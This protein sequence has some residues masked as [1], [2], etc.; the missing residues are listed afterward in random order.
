MGTLP[1][2]SLSTSRMHAPNPSLAAATTLLRSL[3]GLGLRH[4]VASPGSRNTPLLYAAADVGL[5]VWSVIDERSAGFAAL[6]AARTLGEPVAVTCTSGSAA[7]H[8]LPAVVE[9]SQ[10]RVPLLVLT[11]D[12]PDELRHTGAPQTVDQVGIYGSFVRWAVSTGT[13]EPTVAWMNH[14]AGTAARAW[15]ELSAGPVHVNLPFREPLGATLVGAGA[16]LATL[17]P[18]APPPVVA[19]VDAAPLV[20]RLGPRP[21]VVAGDGAGGPGLAA[22]ADR[23][24]VL[25]DPLTTGRR[26]PLLL[27]GNV[28]ARIGALDRHPPSGVLRIGGPPTSKALVGWLGDHP[29]TPQ[30]LVDPVGRRDP[31]GS[32]TLHLPADPEVAAT[33]L[34]EWAG[35]WV[36]D[37][38]A[39]T[40]VALDDAIDF[41]IGDLP[42]PSEPAVAA[43]VTAA[44]GDRDL[45]VGSSMPVRDVGD[46][47]RPTGGRIHGTRG[48]NG[49]DGLISAAA[50]AAALGGRPVVALLGD[51]A[52]LHDVGG[53]LTAHRLGVDL[54]VV[55][56]DNRG[57]GIF[58]FLPQADEPGPFELLAT[59]HDHDL[60]AIADA[61]GARHHLVGDA[62]TL[63]SLVAD[64]VGGVAVIQVVTD[65][66]DNR[67]LHDDLLER[68]R[69]ALR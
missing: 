24:P 3:A 23:V 45:W 40:W 7:A 68:A 51:V 2:G 4:L 16:P 27:R 10:S 41:A 32:A 1:T 49:I 9:A 37:G 43:V 50:G 66:D 6:G 18:A 13:P 15:R 31:A 8:Y 52:F 28:A 30:V 46:F 26:P 21:L 55:V 65:R 25:A 14:L 29:E 44:V 33:S 56:V 60:G 63:A 58:S 17:A 19:T 34:A 64:P 20:A 59:P 35:T 54:T 42:F 48:A 67:R 12:R 11:A 36:A 22:L 47:G 61:M 57:G 38:W 53:L 69:A 62:D 39:G 5:T